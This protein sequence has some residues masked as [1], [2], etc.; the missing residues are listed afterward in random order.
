MATLID[1]AVLGQFR[2]ALANW[3]FTGYI[4]AKDVVLAWIKA[5]LAGR[6]LKDVAKSMHDHLQGGGT[7]DQMPE[8]RP[9]WSARPFHYD[10]R[11]MVASRLLYVETI[12]Q[13]DDPTDPTI[14]V[15]SIHDV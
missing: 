5:N 13:D 11:V 3:R 9:E 8:T 4:T 12:L 6:T 2:A 14:H 1:A 7:I 10:F 15:V